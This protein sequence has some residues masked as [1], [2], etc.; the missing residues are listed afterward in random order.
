MPL[1]PEDLRTRQSD[2]RDV[3]KCLGKAAGEVLVQEL[4][5]LWPHPCYFFPVASSQFPNL[6]N[7]VVTLLIVESSPLCFT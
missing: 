7:V 2:K 1:P 5:D 4:E 3:R 6:Q